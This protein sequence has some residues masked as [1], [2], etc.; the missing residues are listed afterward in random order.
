MKEV[1]IGL[2]LAALAA[3]VVPAVAAHTST[4]LEPAVQQAGLATQR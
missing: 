4:P 3:I 1:M 2:S